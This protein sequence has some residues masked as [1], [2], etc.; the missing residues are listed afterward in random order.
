MIDRQTQVSDYIKNMHNIFILKNFSL[1]IRVDISSI[2]ISGAAFLLWIWKPWPPI[3]Q[4]FLRGAA[5]Q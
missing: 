1:F 5:N 2:V 4:I 3:V